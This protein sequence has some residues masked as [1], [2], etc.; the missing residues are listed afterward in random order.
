MYKTAIKEKKDQLKE[1]E[2][3]E[4]L[5]YLIEELTQINHKNSCFERL[6]KSII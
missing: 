3:N 5:D 2:K 6:L 1:T 4:K